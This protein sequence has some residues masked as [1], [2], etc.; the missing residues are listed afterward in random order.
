M[1]VITEEH[2][3]MAREAGACDKIDRYSAGMPI[4][5]ISRDH[6]DWFASRFP[7]IAAEASR[8]M[9]AESGIVIKGAVP[10]REFGYDFGS[11]YGFGFGF[12]YG[13]GFGSA[14]GSGCGV[15]YEE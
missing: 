8:V 13:Y 4:S 9:V 3:R 15:I 1:V 2:L 14:S 5:R 12:G 11:G 10:L 7:A 6:L